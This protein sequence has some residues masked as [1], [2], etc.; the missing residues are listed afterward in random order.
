M[1]DS[2]VHDVIGPPTDAREQKPKVV[3]GTAFLP[4]TL[5]VLLVLPLLASY[6]VIPSGL[7]TFPP[8]SI[9]ELPWIQS[10]GRVLGTCAYLI[11][12]GKLM[13]QKRL[14]GAG[15]MAQ[16]L[17]ALVA[18]VEDAGTRHACGTH[19]YIGKPLIHIK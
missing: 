12:L 13:E 16:Q 11:H 10:W 14:Q 1:S 6:Q 18:F 15:G 8:R 3:L 5:P 2:R 7:D 4:H 19:V 9:P 17:R